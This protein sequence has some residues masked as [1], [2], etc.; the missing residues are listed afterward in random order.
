MGHLWGMEE[1]EAGPS[2]YGGI[3]GQGAGKSE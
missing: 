1:S 2:G 3:R